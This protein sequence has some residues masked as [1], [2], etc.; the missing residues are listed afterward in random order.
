M[1]KENSSQTCFISL[2]IC[3][4]LFVWIRLTGFL[5]DLFSAGYLWRR[6]CFRK[7][8]LVRVAYLSWGVCLC[9]CLSVPQPWEFRA[10]SGTLKSGKTLSWA[11]SSPVFLAAV[12]VMHASRVHAHNFYLA[13]V[14]RSCRVFCL[15][16]LIFGVFDLR[17]IRK[18][19]LNWG[20][21][22]RQD[23]SAVPTPPQSAAALSCP[24]PSH[25][26][27]KHY[28]ACTHTGDDLLCLRWV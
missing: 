10:G 20:R 16:G 11:N 2:I 9:V 21:N 26:R 19:R 13:A 25:R 28:S 3:N 5:A 7:M 1:K 8:I 15:S 14:Q 6:C 17:L 24:D 22:E 4:L 12:V 18:M 27:G 23:T